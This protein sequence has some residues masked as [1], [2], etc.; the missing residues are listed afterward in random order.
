[1]CRCRLSLSAS[2]LAGGLI[3]CQSVAS[4]QLQLSANVV[5]FL[6]VDSTP[7]SV[8]FLATTPISFSVLIVKV[9]CMAHGIGL[10]RL[11]FVDCRC[12]SAV[13]LGGRTAGVRR[14][15]LR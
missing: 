5:L 1:M 4:R 13:S 10:S 2:Y 9:C 7:K 14:T 6:A 12:K 15:A 8:W 11:A 3:T